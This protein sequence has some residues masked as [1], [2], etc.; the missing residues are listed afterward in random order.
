V[1]QGGIPKA[2]YAKVIRQAGK[3]S[4]EL[5][6]EPRLSLSIFGFQFEHGDRLDCPQ[7]PRLR[8]AQK[9][10]FHF[11]G[12]ANLYHMVERCLHAE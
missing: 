5:S 2:F 11:A 9:L 12:S 4:S 8:L 6:T 3:L 1:K 7:L 10:D